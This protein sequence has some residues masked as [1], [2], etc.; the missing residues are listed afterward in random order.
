MFLSY[1]QMYN[2]LS[3]GLSVS[4][5]L[6]STASFITGLYLSELK[7]F[8]TKKKIAPFVWL[9]ISLTSISTLI[10]ILNLIIVVSTISQNIFLILYFMVFSLSPII[11]I[12]AI[13][14]IL[15]RYKPL[16]E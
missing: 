13:T 16:E 9:I 2:L 5:I 6:V 3:L 11:P 14:F 15:V 4:S 12:I 1:D 7:K 10:I 8:P